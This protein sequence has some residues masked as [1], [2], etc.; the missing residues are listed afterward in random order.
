MARGLY[1]L[2]AQ[3]LYW[4][5]FVYRRALVRT[6][7]V[8]VTGTHGKT[9]SKELLAAAL[10]S[11]R[12]TFRSAHNE[13]TG[14]PLTL[15][16]L[17]VR[18]WHRFAVIEIGVGRPGEMRRLAR[19]VRPDVA[20]VLTV[21]RAHVKA[22][23]DR[24]THAAEKAI[25]L[26]EMR[27][28]GLAV[29]NADDPLV[30]R[31]AAAVRGRVLLFGTS[32]GLG[33]WAE[34]ATS[35]WPDRLELDLRTKDGDACHVRTR[36]VGTHW[37]TS[38]VAAVAAARQLGVPLQHAADAV[39]TVEP[40]LSRMQ[41]MLLPNGAIILRDDF[42]G[43]LDAFAPA[44]RVMAEA[45]AARRIVVIS[46][47]SDFGNATSRR[48]AVFVGGEA[49]RVADVLL[50]VGIGAPHGRRGAIAAGMAPGNVHGIV[51]YREAAGLLAGLT[52][53][54][55]L[56]LLRGRIRDH[57]ARLYYAQLGP[58]GCWRAKCEKPIACDVC[59]ELG[60]RP[61]DA[62]RARPAPRDPA[63]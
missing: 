59:P 21:L 43:S 17:R 55:D 38:V 3:A 42:D 5:A 33:A 9:T 36:L 50:L 8:A 34:G 29:L 10:G 35:R 32:P 6:T 27:P 52:R 40:Y 46:D 44:L 60:N 2:V 57:L 58:I 62:D 13:N 53:S 63:G 49:A 16:V 30:A 15:N 37:T 12:P 31:M 51:D 25:L 54:G 56:V 47:V 19:L 11:W 7:F 24:E 26:E 45:R 48:R 23:A 4:V 20:L 28:G 14:L 1:V 41:P 61:A 22:F 18:P 39:F